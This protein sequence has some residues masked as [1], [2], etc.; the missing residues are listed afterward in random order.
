M[1]SLSIAFLCTIVQI[2][3]NF[4][5]HSKDLLKFLIISDALHSRVKYFKVF[6]QL[7]IV[8]VKFILE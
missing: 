8:I 7:T 4:Q 6:I 3:A 5:D 1:K 2:V